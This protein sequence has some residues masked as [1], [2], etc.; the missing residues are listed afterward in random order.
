MSFCDCDDTQPVEHHGDCVQGA[1][2]EQARRA[3]AC[4]RR[5]AAEAPK[6]CEDGAETQDAPDAH[7]ANVE[8]AVTGA[9]K[10]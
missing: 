7:E 2:R 5:R 9:R 4:S 8:G 10:H 6:Q 3:D 1:R